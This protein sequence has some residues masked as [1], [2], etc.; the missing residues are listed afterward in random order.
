MLLLLLLAVAEATKPEQLHI[1]YGNSPDEMVVAFATPKDTT[2]HPLVRWSLDASGPLQQMANASSVDS[3]AG[4]FAVHHA[5]LTNLAPGTV[6][7][8]QAGWAPSSGADVVWS[9]EVSFVAQINDTNRPVRLAM[10]GD[11]G[12]TDDQVLPQLAQESAAQAIDAI[13]LYG[14]MV[15]YRDVPTALPSDEAYG[16]FMN[17]VSDMSGGGSIPFMVTP[18]NGE[19]SHTACCSTVA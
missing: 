8:Y 15:Y 5:T 18:G 1:A 4:L 19:V 2:G 13:I 16:A 7:R 12:Y 11:L 17:D 14:D 6:H 10:F 3:G 9:D